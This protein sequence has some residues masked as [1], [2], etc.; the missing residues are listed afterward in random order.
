M[1]RHGFVP[2]YIIIRSIVNVFAA[3]YAVR[4]RRKIAGSVALIEET[5]GAQAVAITARDRPADVAF[6]IRKQ[7]E[8]RTNN[9]T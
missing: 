4:R 9:A 5:V 1:I 6:V 7:I 3:V 8:V 2:H